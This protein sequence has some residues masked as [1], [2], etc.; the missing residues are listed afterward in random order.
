MKK[1]I[2]SMC[3][4][5][6]SVIAF[7]SCEDVPEPYN[8]PGQGGGGNGETPDDSYISESFSSNFGTF[9]VATVEGNPWTI[10]YNC[11]TGTGYDNSTKTTTPSNSYLVSKPIDLSG[12]TEANMTFEYVLRYKSQGTQEVLI[13]NEYTGDPT[14]T[15]WIDITGNLEESST[16]TDFK[17]FAVNLPAEVIGKNAVVVAFHFACTDKSG[18]WEVKNLKVKEGKVEGGTD[19][20]V[21]DSWKVVKSINSGDYILAAPTTGNNFVVATPI[22]SDRTYGYLYT[23]ATT[24]VDNSTI[25]ADNANVFTFTESE[26]G[27]T[28]QDASG[29]YLI[30]NADKNNFDVNETK[31]ATGAIWNVEFNSAGAAVIKNASTNKIIQYSTQ[32]SSYGEYD[33]LSNILPYLFNATGDGTFIEGGDSQPTGENL[34]TNGDFEAWTGGLPDNWKS[35]STASNA[36][37]SQ[38]NDARG[39]SYAVLVT[40]GGTATKRLAYKEI[41]LKAGTYTFSFYAKSTTTDPSQS[42]AGYVP[43][44]NGAV[45]KYV[46]GGYTTLSNTS[47]TQVT[48]TFTLES[49]A[50]VCLVMMNPKNSDY[51]TSQDILVDDA[52]LTT[53]DGGLADGNDGGDSGNTG[54][55]QTVTVAQFNAAAE[56]TT[57][58]YQ[59]TGTI[60]NLNDGDQYGNFDL[61]D[62]TGTVYVYGVLSEK[63]GAKKQF[64][65]LVSEKG[66]QNGSTITIIGNRGSYQGKIEVTNA[67]FVSVS[68]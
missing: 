61:T 21:G 59:L 33:G 12:S 43:V 62:G 15:T 27:Y 31:P 47:W 14:T 26:G 63:G 5:A 67:Y 66:I 16:Y 34:L 52:T 20:A 4:M 50:T 49:E 32:Y 3:I 9:E 35:T 8:A 56:S 53:A 37:L 29:R 45:G 28:I 24:L 44:T 18:T 60:S 7:S 64:Q 46:Y 1:L 57:V 10:A 39:G 55:V 68:N 38:S 58:W 17:N 25:T 41:A 30:S 65:T 40:K 42:Q 22:S 36:T 48:T 19:E 51:A 11:A 54:D 13:T 2:Y 6:M 23:M